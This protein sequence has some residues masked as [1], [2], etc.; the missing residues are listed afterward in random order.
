MEFDIALMENGSSLVKEMFLDEL[1]DLFRS[2]IHFVKSPVFSLNDF[3]LE[4]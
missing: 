4:V 1:Q 2:G 3:Y